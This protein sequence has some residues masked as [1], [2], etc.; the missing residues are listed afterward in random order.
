MDR[1]HAL[2]C[3]QPWRKTDGSPNPAGAPTGAA[4][5]VET[6]G[7]AGLLLPTRPATVA[8][9]VV[10]VLIGLA[11][12]VPGGLLIAGGGGLAV[13]AGV[14][15]GLL[16]L[17]LLA[18]GVFALTRKQG[19]SGIVLTP[20]HVVLTWVRPV[21]RVPWTT[22]TEV[23]PLALR[24]GRTKGALSQNYLGLAARDHDVTGD[25]MRKVAVRFGPDLV[26][27]V[28]MR[29]L[30]LDQLVVLH[31]LRFYL[32]NPQHRAELAGEDAVRRVESGPL[33][34]S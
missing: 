7:A 9:G 20:E 22:I 12:A 19:D 28:P 21:V 25:R 24:V 1:V 27:A 32:A 11:L 15:L 8:A 26:C 14:V 4:A 29:T 5:T 33:T 34:A 23:R 3:P 2:P 17:L 16:G 13:F 31:A 6:D 18:A 10:L 30:N